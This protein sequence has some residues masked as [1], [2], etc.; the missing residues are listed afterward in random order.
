MAIDKGEPSRPPLDLREREITLTP[1]GPNSGTPW[2]SW[3]R[4]AKTKRGPIYFSQDSSWR[5][6]REDMPGTLYVAQNPAT[7]FKEVFWDDLVSRPPRERRLD[8]LKIEERSLYLCALPKLLE[9][10]DATNTDTLDA[11]SA[12]GG[13]F[14]GAYSICQDWAFALRAHSSKPEGILYES[15]RNKGNLCLALFEEHCAKLAWEF[16]GGDLLI[17]TPELKGGQP[18]GNVIIANVLANGAWNSRAS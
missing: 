18:G 7:A 9:V 16:S 2:L 12:H 13:T 4:I 15:V 1:I 5:F 14:G 3:S 6:S 8:R 17:D 10:I 11:L